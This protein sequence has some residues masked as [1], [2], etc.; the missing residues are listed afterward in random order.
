MSTRVGNI[1][2]QL[3]SDDLEVRPQA[4]VSDSVDPRCSVFVDGG[5]AVRLQLSGTYDDLRALANGI[6]AATDTVEQRKL[7]AALPAG[8]SF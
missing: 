5:S 3:D 7:A 6:L 2:I 8:A 4:E 1:T